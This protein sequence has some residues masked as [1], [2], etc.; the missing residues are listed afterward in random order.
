MTETRKFSKGARILCIGLAIVLLFSIIAS[1]IQTNGGKVDIIEITIPQSNGEYTSALLYKPK[2]ATIDTPAPCVVT[3]PGAGNTKEMQDIALVELSRRGF[4][5][6][7]ID[8][9]DHG[10]SS[11]THESIPYT[12]SQQYQG[13]GMID[14]VDYVYNNLD[15]VDNTK[16]GITGHSTGGRITSYTLN[17]YGRYDRIQAGIEDGAHYYDELYEACHPCQVAAALITA[18][19][20]AYYIIENF[21]DYIDIGLLQSYYDEGVKSQVTRI[22][23]HYAGDMTVSP[24]IKN[25]INQGVPETFKLDKTVNYDVDEATAAKA[26]NF[27]GFAGGTAGYPQVSISNWDNNELVEMEHWYE[28]E[29]TGGRRIVY[30][31]KIAHAEVHFALS[32][33]EDIV[34]F[35]GESLGYPTPVDHVGAYMWK[36]ICNLGAL[37]GLFVFLYGLILVMLDSRLFAPLCGPAPAKIP[38]PN[39]I[40]KVRIAVVLVLLTLIGAFTVE[41]GMEAGAKVLPKI[42]STHYVSWTGNGIGGY[43]AFMGLVSIAVFLLGYFIFDKKRGITTD[44]WGL[45]ISWKKLGLTVLFTVLFF[46]GF[47]AVVYFCYFFFQT[48]FR[49]FIYAIRS[50]SKN[51]MMYLFWY[52]PVFFIYYFA[53]SWTLNASLR[54]ENA[55]RVPNT[56]LYVAMAILGMVLAF[57]IE[58]IANYAGDFLVW[59]VMWVYYLW[60]INMVVTVT[61]ATLLSKV[62]F[63]K[64]GNVWLPAFLNST[65]ATYITIATSRMITFIK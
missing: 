14:V 39:K 51:E 21:P 42:N 6:I 9:Y 58:Y 12:M 49:F 2:T 56:L 16:I 61:L 15:Y 40:A 7:S 36:E 63:E 64:T 62:L 35:F 23:G 26:G 59:K 32:S 10:R 8:L 50:V 13:F 20:P 24:E 52:F 18:N 55:K 11:G 33:A 43:S 27:T 47:Y 34:H 17:E 53:H 25:F 5:V 37:I 29:E 60:M 19:V 54:F 22:D 30:N 1:A 4:V 41:W 31:P 28:N 3:A 45:K 65:M 38:A 46:I 57:A 48:D 44:S